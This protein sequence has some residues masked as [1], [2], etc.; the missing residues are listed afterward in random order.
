MGVFL[1]VCNCS[2]VFH[3]PR[4]PA[5]SLFTQPYASRLDSC[6]ANTFGQSLGKFRSIYRC[7]NP[8][9][10]LLAQLGDIIPDDAIEVIDVKMGIREI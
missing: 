3:W 6:Q 2:R 4:L 5:G 10:E 9:C 1:R 8:V 7:A